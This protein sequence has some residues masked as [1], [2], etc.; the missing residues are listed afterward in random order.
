MRVFCHLTIIV[1]CAILLS[2]NVSAWERWHKY[3]KTGIRIDYSRVTDIDSGAFLTVMRKWSE[4]A[5][6]VIVTGDRFICKDVKIIFKVNGQEM[7]VKG[8]VL[9]NRFAI[10]LSTESDWIE[11]LSN[12]QDIMIQTIDSCDTETTSQFDINE[13]IFTRSAPD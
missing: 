2:E 1:S 10:E 11:I 13:P 7:P 5:T 3:S 12:K 6:L 8:T 9:A 4:D